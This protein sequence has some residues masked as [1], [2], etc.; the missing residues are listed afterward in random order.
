MSSE[1]E[2][3]IRRY[4]LQELAEDERR[5]VEEKMM[6]DDAF[7]EEIT[8]AEDELVSEYTRCALKGVERQRFEQSFLTTP[9]GRRDVNFNEAFR[10]RIPVFRVFRRII[11]AV[12]KRRCGHCVGS[13]D[14][15]CS[16]QRVAVCCGTQ[17]S[18]RD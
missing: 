15:S 12:S 16:A 7:F 10:T 5:S 3:T 4:L 11:L 8:F 13:D 17:S 14:H 18:V 9:Q 1:D 6:A 2:R